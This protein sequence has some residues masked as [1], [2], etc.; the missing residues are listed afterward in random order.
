[1]YEKI[2]FKI[3]QKNATTLKYVREST[4]GEIITLQL[5]VGGEEGKVKIL[6][7]FSLKDLKDLKEDEEKDTASSVFG[8]LDGI[9]GLFEFLTAI[10]AFTIVSSGRLKKEE[11]PFMSIRHALGA[12]E[13][14]QGGRSYIT[15]HG[16]DD[17][18]ALKTDI[19]R[20]KTL[21]TCLLKVPIFDF[22]EGHPLYK[23]IPGNVYNVL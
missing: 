21:F 1:M 7:S 22:L 4:T 19:D 20:C 10:H 23:Y 2:G 17:P 6:L 12:K 8:T 11:D 9:A 15:V 16:N 18:T 13:R 5:G 14:A 3:S